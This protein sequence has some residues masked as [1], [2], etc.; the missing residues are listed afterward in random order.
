MTT[1]DQKRT[2]YV[3]SIADEAFRAALRDLRSTLRDAGGFSS[4]R[5][6]TTVQ[7]MTL[8]GVTL[9]AVLTYT[10]QAHGPEVAVGVFVSDLSNTVTQLYASAFKAAVAQRF[11]GG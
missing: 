4:V 2:I 1:H 5:R 7:P 6:S 11:R 8:A 3:P 10:I 9:P